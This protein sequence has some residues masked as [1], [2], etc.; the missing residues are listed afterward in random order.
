MSRR[1]RFPWLLVLA[2]AAGATGAQPPPNQNLGSGHQH[3][4]SRA[5]VPGISN[6]ARVTPTLYRGGQPHDGGLE[7]LAKM[8]INTIV[9]VR[10]TGADKERAAAE[11]LGMQFVALPWHCL[12]PKDDPIAKFLL[13]LRENPGKKVFVH[14][15]YGD[16]RTGMM[17]AAYRMAVQ[18]W[19]A[20]EAVQEM[21]SFG[22]HHAICASLVGYEKS[23]PER[24]KNDP[25]FQNV[26]PHLDD[27][28]C[29]ARPSPN[30]PRSRST[31]RSRYINLRFTSDS[32]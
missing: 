24:L 26:V 14:C 12:F 20:E 23:F 16:D 8:G 22:F 21:N 4:S 17:I 1:G 27:T 10:L 15:R 3:M 29:G 11:K 6:F 18:G 13:Y 2:L 31:T 30:S 5:T 7:S 9:D 25:A 19:T 28:H 32:C